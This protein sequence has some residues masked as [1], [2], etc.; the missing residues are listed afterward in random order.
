MKFTLYIFTLK[1]VITFLLLVNSPSHTVLSKASPQD[2]RQYRTAQPVP[3]HPDQATC[4]CQSLH[5]KSV[6]EVPD[7]PE[8]TVRWVP[9]ESDTTVISVIYIG[10][11]I[12]YVA[13]GVPDVSKERI[14]SVPDGSEERI[15]SVLYDAEWGAQGVPE[16]YN[17]TKKWTIKIEIYFI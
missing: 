11:G 3:R 17:V 6:R 13:W 14:W 9:G 5:R 2:V 8:A 15:W 10:W 12:L 1:I 16:G 7:Y 4:M